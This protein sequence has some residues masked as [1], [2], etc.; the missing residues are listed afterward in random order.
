MVWAAGGT[1]VVCV[2]PQEP[3]AGPVPMAGGPGPGVPVGGTGVPQKPRN[4]RT[5]LILVM[6]AG[7]VGLLCLGGVGVAISLYD[8]ATKIERTEPDAV[9]DNFLGAYLANRDDQ[10]ASLYTCKSG[11]DL[12]KLSAF[13]TDV[14]GREKRYSI[15]INVTWRNF[16][17]HVQEGKA[18]VAVDIV[19]TIADGSE[20]TFDRWQFQL[21]DEGGWRVCG[22]IPA[23]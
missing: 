23:A 4:R 1:S 16:D 9:V 12:S 3:T 7:I 22:A 14:Q 2:Q 17:I 11:L 8:D 6:I 20:E 21:V 18:S 13:R 10:E 5:R 15:G 19:R